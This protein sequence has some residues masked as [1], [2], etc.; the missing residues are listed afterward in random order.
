MK[1]KS[2]SVIETV[3]SRLISTFFKDAYRIQ[4][5]FLPVTDLSTSL[6]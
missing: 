6:P 2:I 5:F 3:K 1:K 4:G